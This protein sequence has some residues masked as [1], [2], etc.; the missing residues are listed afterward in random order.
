MIEPFSSRG[1][2][3]LFFPVSETR[4]KPEIVAPDGVSVTGNGGFPSSFFGTSAA[5]PHAAAVA[6]LLLDR[7]PILTPE[8]VGLALMEAAVDLGQ[9]GVDDSFGFGRIDALAAVDGLECGNGILDADEECD[10]G[11]SVDGDG[12]SRICQIETC[13]VCAGNPSVCTPD[14][15]TPCDDGDSCT[16]GDECAGGECASDPPITTCTGYDGCCPESCDWQNDNDCL[17]ALPAMSPG[18]WTTLVG[19]LALAMGLALRRH[20]RTWV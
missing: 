8:L 3:Q 13:F 14:D 1:P 20:G 19:L 6:A 18:G 11:N 9:P 7:M 12:C 2:A 4:Q 5:A 10:D 17:V 16:N 15:G